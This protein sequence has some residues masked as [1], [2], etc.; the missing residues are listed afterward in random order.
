MKQEKE[1]RKSKY[2][3]NKK[4]KACYEKRYSTTYFVFEFKFSSL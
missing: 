4:R 1:I 2:L 3:W